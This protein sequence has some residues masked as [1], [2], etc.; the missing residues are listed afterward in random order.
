[1]SSID[2]ALCAKDLRSFLRNLGHPDDGDGEGD[3]N[4]GT[5]SDDGT[6]KFRGGEDECG[7]KNVDERGLEE[8]DPAELHQLVIAE[9][10]HGPTDE[11]EEQDE[12]NEFGEEAAHVD[13]AADAD[14]ENFPLLHVGIEPEADGPTT[15]EERDDQCGANHHG[16]VFSHEEHGE[17]HGR[18]FCMITADEFSF[19]FGEIEGHAVGL[20]E[21]GDCEYQEGDECGDPEESGI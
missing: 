6:G 9:P 14:A 3:E 8:D 13:E 11:D 21:D 16:R 2:N 4:D 12:Y 1:M 5:D 17:F 18:V 15:E 20:R 10:R 7:E 19:A